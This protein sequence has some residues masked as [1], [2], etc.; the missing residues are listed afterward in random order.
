MITPTAMTFSR[1]ERERQPDLINVTV[2]RGT[3]PEQATALRDALSGIWPA[4]EVRVFEAP[5]LTQ[6]RL[7]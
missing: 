5:N 2:P 3:T 4:R 7:A 1:D 6:A